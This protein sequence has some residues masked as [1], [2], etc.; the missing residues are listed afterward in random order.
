MTLRRVA[1]MMT[2]ALLAMATA[3]ARGDEKPKQQAKELA[4]K[5]QGEGSDRVSQVQDFCKAAQLDAKEK[6]YA[7]QCS[8]YRSGLIQDDTAMLAS[9]I[10]AYKSHDL[11]R[12]ESQAKLVSGYDQKLSGQAR[13]VLDLIHNQR[14]LNQVQAA[15]KTGELDQILSLSQ[16][17][18]NA[19]AK[20]AV[21]IYVSNVNAYKGYMSQAQSQAQSNP[22]EA[23]RQLNLAKT[24]NPNGPGNPAGMIEELQKAMQAKNA[25]PPITSGPKTPPPSSG[26]DTAKKVAKLLSDA[27][28]A[29]KQ[30]KQPDALNDY[31][32]VLKLQPGNAEAQASTD[33]IQLA[34]K[35]DPAAAKNE[36]RAAIRSFYSSQFDDA[37]RALL[38]YLES[39]QTATDPGV[40]DFYLG[41]TLI[42]RSILQTPRVQWKGASPEAL[43]AFQQA[44]KANYQP[45][46]NYVSPAILKVWDFTNQ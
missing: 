32:A 17:I 28:E 27:R 29:E 11:D 31:A 22:A 45:L 12:A 34:I 43:S 8:N 1:W 39:P 44:R 20:A 23:I 6:K 40:A 16:S 38:S 14:L 33:R 18:T 46:R 37:R 36:L 9:A 26:A 42:E 15:W 19:D 5:A 41:A 24:L 35:N 2:L 4:E 3:P 7:D 30:G 25:P 10:A 13:L 21:A